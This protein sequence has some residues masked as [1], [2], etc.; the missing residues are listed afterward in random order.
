MVIDLNASVKGNI[1]KVD[2]SITDYLASNQNGNRYMPIHFLG[3]GGLDHSNY[4]LE[5]NFIAKQDHKVDLYISAIKNK[6]TSF[7]IDI[8]R[9]SNGDVRT[10]AL[11]DFKYDKNLTEHKISFT[12]TNPITRMFISVAN[13][14]YVAIDG[15][16]WNSP[17]P[18]KGLPFRKGLPFP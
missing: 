5:L 18:S 3:Y 11:H 12:V 4:G 10:T 1:G 2:N 17:T 7:M 8:D 15:I 6:E 14:E 13:N 9:Y 16:G